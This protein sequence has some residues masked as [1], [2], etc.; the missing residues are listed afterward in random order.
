MTNPNFDLTGKIAV[1]TG[2]SRG[3][4]EAI[5]CTYAS[6][7]ASVV[8]AGRK[9]A[10]VQAVARKIARAGGETF[11]TQAHTG[12]EKSVKQLI[13]KVID[14]YDGIDILVNNA[15]TNPHFGHI[16]TSGES[17][18]DKI[19]EINVKAYFNLA[20]ACYESMKERGGG[21]IINVASSAGEIPT[22][23]MGVYCVSKAAV[24]ML[25][26]VLAL[27]LATDNIQVNAIAPG[28]VKT[29]FSQALWGNSQIYEAVLNT[30]PQHRIAMPDEISGIAL[31]L[32]SPASSYTTGATFVVDGGAL[33]GGN[34]PKS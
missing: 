17:E 7:G 33:I 12:N 26:K 16:M 23:G 8:L 22:P 34:V 30:I 20:K 11:A 4:G 32:A 14:A 29:K 10:G 18:W 27:E 1:I 31:Y 28:L 13:D 9:Q 19:Y 5:A 2:A 6:A 24:L 21:K 3:I 15:A 25:T